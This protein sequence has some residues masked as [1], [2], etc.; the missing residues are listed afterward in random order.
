MTPEAVADLT[1][2]AIELDPSNCALLVV[3]I[4]N[5]VMHPD[6]AMAQNPALDL[7]VY[8]ASRQP[9]LALVDACRSAGVP[10]IAVH[11]AYDGDYLSEPMRAKLDS[12]GILGQVSPKGA[13]GSDV[14]DE[15]LERKPDHRV[16]KSNFTPFSERALCWK[17]GES[18]ELDSY[19]METVNND[20]AR[21]TAGRPTL[22]E[23]YGQPGAS[24][25]DLLSSLGVDTL[26]IAGGATHVCQDAAVSSASERGYRVIEPVDACGSEDPSK[27]WSYLHNHGLFKSELCT[28]AAVAAALV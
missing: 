7:S 4:A 24:L 10:W 14:I 11:S 3:D 2:D 26:I 17:P 8:R 19:L 15:L 21:K 16:I 28:V 23:M 1:A 12:M 22:A 20:D 6:G 9:L 25:D 18:D 5:D 27:H 13:W